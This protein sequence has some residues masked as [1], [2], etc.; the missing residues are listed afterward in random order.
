M[1]WYFSSMESVD[2]K[3]TRTVTKGATR[4]GILG[5]AQ[6]KQ[7]KQISNI[8]KQAMEMMKAALGPWEWKRLKIN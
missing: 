3:F 8:S 4:Y 2:L 7:I 6:N 5:Q 1:R